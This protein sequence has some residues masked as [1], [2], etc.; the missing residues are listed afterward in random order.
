MSEFKSA[1]VFS[2]IEKRIGEEPDLIKKIAGIYQF[3]VVNEAKQTKS[4]VVDVKNSPG[5][6]RSG[7]I[8]NPDCT[9]SISDEDF[10]ALI[11]GKKNGQQLFM[12]GK[13][14]MKG[15][16]GL[17]MKLDQLVKKKASL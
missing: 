10:T 13:L 17:A 11:S 3:D 15:N 7:T 12:Q 14:K 2:E 16:M 1:P 6:V 8:D 9:I 4:W 5:S